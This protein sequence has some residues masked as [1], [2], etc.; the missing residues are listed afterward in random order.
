MMTHDPPDKAYTLWLNPAI[1]PSHERVY[2]TKLVQERGPDRE[3][4]SHWSG[5]F[6]GWQAATPDQ[7]A[8]TAFKTASDHQR[9][10]WK[11]LTL[12]QA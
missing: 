5:K 2:P 8:E 7:A 12:S 9:K 6:W 10:S 11:D 1:K 4:F 3:G